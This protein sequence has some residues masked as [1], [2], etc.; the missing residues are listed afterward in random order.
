MSPGPLTTAHRGG[1]HFQHGARHRF[2]PLPH[3]GSTFAPRQRFGVSPSEGG[4]STITLTPD[5]QVTV[6]TDADGN[7]AISID[8]KPAE[9]PVETG[10]QGAAA[11][12]RPAHRRLLPQRQKMSVATAPDGTVTITPDNGNQLL[13]LG[14]PAMGEVDVVEV[15][16][17]AEALR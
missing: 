2:A 5:E 8:A 12:S 4:G 3:N 14:D 1:I 17:P 11:R 16:A 9:E 6:S 15:P 13:V 7:V 10:P